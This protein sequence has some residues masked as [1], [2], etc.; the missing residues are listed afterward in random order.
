MPSRIDQRRLARKDKKSLIFA[1]RAEL[2]IHLN[3]LKTEPQSK[4][5]PFSSIRKFFRL[6]FALLVIVIVISGGLLIFL[7]RQTNNLQSNK[8]ILFVQSNLDGGEANIIL[9]HFSPTNSKVEVGLFP[10]ELSVDILGGYGQYP[11]RSVFPLLTLDKKPASF[12]IAAYTYALKIPID[13]VVSFS[14][15]SHL[16]ESPKISSL[17]WKLLT[18]KFHSQ[19]SFVDR[20]RL[21]QF[22][23]KVGQAQTTSHQIDSLAEWQKI[24]AQF[25]FS[26]LGN[27]C[28]IAVLNTTQTAGTGL[29]IAQ[30]LE[31]SGVSI[32][33]L[34]D[35]PDQ[36]EQT[37]ILVNQKPPFCQEVVNQLGS[38]FPFATKVE[39]NSKTMNTYR[40]NIVVLIGQDFAQEFAKKPRQK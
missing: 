1:P 25:R 22:A 37:K 40:A 30:V 17:L 18:F 14:E 11:L 33:R 3:E 24:K 15:N 31:E 10:A 27:D 2:P 4:F 5:S 12:I 20:L 9:A 28:A 13:G 8:N 16:T 7:I 29:S 19:I 26:S 23:L 35:T 34:T 38:L 39:V 6:V 21:Y 32:I 36:L